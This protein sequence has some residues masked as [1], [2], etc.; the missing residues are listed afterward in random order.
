MLQVTA[1]AMPTNEFFD[2]DA[3]QNKMIAKADGILKNHI[4]TVH[5]KD[6][7]RIMIQ[8]YDGT[9]ITRQLL[10]QEAFCNKNW[11]NLLKLTVTPPPGLPDINWNE[12]YSK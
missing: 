8:E 10:V 9:P 5:K 11:I 1:I 12:L 2:W 6:S 4:F 7:D 3:L